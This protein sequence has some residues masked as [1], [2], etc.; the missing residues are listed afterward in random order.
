MAG[1]GAQACAVLASATILASES[2]LSLSRATPDAAVL[3][4][5]HAPGAA[6]TSWSLLGPNIRERTFYELR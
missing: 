2:G 6:R 3:R 4:E 1:I 5:R